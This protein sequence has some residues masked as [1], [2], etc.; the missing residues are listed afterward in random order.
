MATRSLATMK[1]EGLK[2]LRKALKATENDFSDLKAVHEEVADMVKWGA[3]SKMPQ[4]SGDLAASYFSRATKTTGM[5]GSQLVYSGVS[6]FGGRIPNPGTKKGFVG[7]TNKG[8]SKGKKGG[9]TQSGT[10]LHKPT[11]R[12]KGQSSYYTY[13]AAKEN[14]DKIQDMYKKEILRFAEHNGLEVK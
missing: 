2:E 9:Y 14:E 13:P 4:R 5:V 7:P 8:T 3:I 6:E 1:V 12:S 10:H 11:A